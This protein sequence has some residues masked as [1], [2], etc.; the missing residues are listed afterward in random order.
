[1]IVQN[2]M[3][4]LLSL[5]AMEPPVRIKAD[6]IRDE[7]VKVLQSIR[8]IPLQN[9]DNHVIRGQYGPGF[10]EGVP[11]K[12]YRQEENVAEKSSVESYVAMQLFIDNWR[13]AGVPFYLRA[14]KRLPKKATEIA[15]IYKEAPGVLFH[16]A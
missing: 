7:K 6:A 2:H 8:P 13:W 11:V 5:V 15:V 10:I 3:M 16:R 4:Q 14:G 9:L 12:G 1:D